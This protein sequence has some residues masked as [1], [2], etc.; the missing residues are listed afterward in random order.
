[1]FVKRA[2][3][4]AGV[5]NFFQAASSAEE[6]RRYLQGEAEYEDRRK[7]PFPNVIL[8]DLK[9]PGMDGFDLLQWLKEHP[10]CGVIPTIVFTSSAQD[11]D[12]RRAYE[13]GANAYIKKPG[14]LAELVRVI[15]LM[16]EFWGVCER[17]A[18]PVTEKCER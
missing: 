16:Y 6:G 3:D 5:A 8:M 17:P 1:M 10:D 14:T 9:M 7:F 12:I 18:I 13:M 2:L 11:R 4:K 15:H